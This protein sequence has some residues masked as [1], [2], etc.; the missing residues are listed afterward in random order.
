MA[1]KDSIKVDELFNKMKEKGLDNIVETFIENKLD[2]SETL[3]LLLANDQDLKELI[4]VVGER[5]LVKKLLKNVLSVTDTDINEQHEI[6]SPIANV[7]NSEFTQQEDTEL[8]ILKKKPKPSGGQKTLVVEG[9]SLTIGPTLIESEEYL[10]KDKDIAKSARIFNKDMKRPLK[11]YEEAVNTAA[12]QLALDDPTLLAK[13]GTLLT[14]A[15]EKVRTDGSY[16]YKKGYS[17]SESSSSTSSEEDCKH[18]K[19]AKLMSDERQKEIQNLSQLIS[20]SEDGIK[21]RQL[22]LGKAKTVNNYT[23]CAEITDKIRKLFKEK[24]DYSKQL[25][26]LQKKESK[27]VWYHKNKASTSAASPQDKPPKTA[28]SGGLKA[29]FE[30]MSK[31]NEQSSNIECFN[32]ESSDTSS[33]GDL[34]SV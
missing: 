17:R 32:F 13:R 26:A 21:M 1:S 34:D 31:N 11:P 2:S 16:T 29:A 3:L 28:A 18:P 8:L 9:G 27:S 10:D 7:L 23:K 22:E 25:A 24:N 5:L 20:M 30:R 6:T 4:P 33:S 14:K 12:G 15:V 19:R